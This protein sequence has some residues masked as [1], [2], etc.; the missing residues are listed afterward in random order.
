MRLDALRVVLAFVLPLAAGCQK[1]PE[2][3]QSAQ[4]AEPLDPIKAAFTADELG[5][6]LD[7]ESLS[8]QDSDFLGALFEHD[9]KKAKALLAEGANPLLDCGHGCTALML[10]AATGDQELVDLMKKAGAAETPEAG[11]YLEIL[12]FRENAARD[13]F[14]KCLAEIEK[15]SGSKPKP[16]ERPGAYTLELDTKKAKAFL[17]RYHEAY[18]QK[19]CYIV[20]NEQHFGIGGRPDTL[21]ILPTTDKYAVMAFTDVNGA[22]YDIDTILVIK[23][24]KRLEKTHP[25]LLTG[26]GFDFLSGR[27]KDKVADPKALAKAM[28]DFCPDIVDQGTGSLEALADELAKSNE[29]F[30]WWD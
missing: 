7:W 18:L 11:P 28:Y 15:A 24:M 21:L 6:P 1:K 2:S 27:F 14:R 3:G 5:K 30:F 20:L 29:L 16:L 23:W 26:C 10:A 13:E 12:R 19:G 22:N 17:D 8:K 4:P 9:G 25:Y